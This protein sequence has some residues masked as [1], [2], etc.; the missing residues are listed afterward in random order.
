[1]LSLL[2]HPCWSGPSSL[3]L[4][5]T[6]NF[7][8]AS[9][10]Q[11]SGQVS[12]QVGNQHSWWGKSVM[13]SVTVSPSCFH[14]PPPSSPYRCILSI[15]ELEGPLYYHLRAWLRDVDRFLARVSGPSLSVFVS[16]S[17]LWFSQMCLFWKS[18]RQPLQ[19]VI[20][21]RTRLF[22]FKLIVCYLHL[23]HER[24]PGFN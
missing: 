21:K 1:M 23:K 2:I 11:S 10:G 7:P 15:M 4:L 13:I 20:F 17:H 12:S 3:V 16:M 18:M 9:A 19:T 5:K 24:S 14:P 6:L 8:V 22:L